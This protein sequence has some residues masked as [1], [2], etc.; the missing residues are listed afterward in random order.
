MLFSLFSDE[1][2]N[3]YLMYYVEDD[4]PLNMKFWLA[5]SYLS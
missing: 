1:M 2:C 3:F 4:E 5:N